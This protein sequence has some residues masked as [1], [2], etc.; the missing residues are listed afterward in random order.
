MYVS[1]LVPFLGIRPDSWTAV[2]DIRQEDCLRPVHHE[3]L[4]ARLGVVR[5]LQRIDGSTTTHLARNFSSRLKIRGFNPCKTMPLALSTCP[6]AVGCAT[7]VQSTRMFFVVAEVEEFLSREL[8]VVVGDEGVRD[9]EAVNDVGE[10]CYDLLG[11]DVHYGSS[12]DPLEKLVDG[13]E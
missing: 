1:N 7:A 10:Q 9:A 2:A 13:H 12:L 4:V 5:G 8:S 3:E 11:A 6:F